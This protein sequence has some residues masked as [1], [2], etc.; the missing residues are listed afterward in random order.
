MTMHKHLS[1]LLAHAR[2]LRRDSTDAE[3]R[4]WKRLR[5]RRLLGYKSRRQVPIGPYIV[6]FVCKERRVVVE[7][8]GSQHQ[9]QRDYDQRRT[10]FLNSQGY[11][12]LR[13]WNNE[14]L[15]QGEA[16]LASIAQV[17]QPPQR[18]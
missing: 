5:G 13:Y 6:D 9:E 11:Q 14:V 2:D 18:R 1:T 16:V 4:L 12:V 10:A 15:Q 17:L 7:V 8:D 3:H